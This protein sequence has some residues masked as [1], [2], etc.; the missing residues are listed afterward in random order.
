MTESCDTGDFCFPHS[1]VIANLLET[2]LFWLLH[3]FHDA[4][5]FWDS[6]MITTESGSL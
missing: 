5:E 3:V 4:L 6:F 1:R 2:S